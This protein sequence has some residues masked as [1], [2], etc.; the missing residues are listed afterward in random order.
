[1]R[2]SSC[3]G[4]RRRRTAA[5]GPAACSPA[6]RR[7]TSCG[8]ALHRAGLATARRARACRRRPDAH[9]RLHRGGR[10]LRAAGQQAD[11]RRSA[12]PARRSSSASSRCSTRCGSSSRSGQF[13][14]D[15][16]AAG[17]R[18][19]SGIRRRAAAAVRP[20]GAEARIGPYTL[21]GSYHPS[22]QNTFTGRLTPGDV[23]RRSRAC[24]GDRQA[25]AADQRLTTAS[26]RSKTTPSSA[27][28]SAMNC[29]SIAIRWPRPMHS[30]CIVTVSRPPGACVVG[31]AQLA[32]PDLED[33]RRRGQAVRARAGLEHAASR[34]SPSRPAPRPARPAGPT[35]CRPRREVSVAVADPVQAVVVGHQRRVVDVP[36][37]LDQARASSGAERPVRRPEAR[38]G[39]AGDRRG[40]PP[41]TARGSPL[42]LVAGAPRSPRGTSRGRRARGR[43]PGSRRCRRGMSSACGPGRTTSPGCRRASSSRIR[44]KPTRGPNS[45]CRSSPAGRR[46]GPN[47]RWRRG[48]R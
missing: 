28:A 40:R 10:P 22:Q 45:A 44:V 3:W 48:R 33:L 18:R 32:G 19:R 4:S 31:V 17:V 26:R 1:M 12:T 39:L 38:P 13:G 47:R 36:G 24:R 15:A 35:W 41:R 46:G 8:A 16:G 23:R 7:A 25:S 30:G 37:R 27:R 21:L 14:W 42:R 34:P 2:G 20:P 9:R 6:T 5:T 43:R 29:S 11:A